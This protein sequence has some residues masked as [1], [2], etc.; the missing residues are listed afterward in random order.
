MRLR[1][2][3]CVL[4]IFITSACVD[5]LHFDLE[6][7]PGLTGMSIYGFISDQPGPYQ[8]SV[9]QTFDIE[10]KESV[11][12]P[13]SVSHVYLSDDVGKTEELMPTQPGIFQT[14][15]TGITGQAGRIY[16]VR[17]EL[18]D[19]R[20]Y[21]SVGDTLLASGIIDSIYYSFNNG[22]VNGT[23]PSYGFDIY[24][25]SS[26]DI[27]HN[28]F[29]WS[30]KATFKSETHP[31]L[32]REEECFFENGICNFVP[33]C[34]GYKNIGTQPAN[35]IFIKV[36]DCECCTCWY[37]IFNSHVLLSD[38]YYSSA[39]N[40]PD[41]KIDRI[42][43]DGWIFMHKLHLEVSMFGLTKQS[44]RFWKAIRDQQNA[45]GNL[46]Q[47]VSGKTPGNFYQVSG[48]ESPALG[49]FYAA[50]V[51]TK[52]IDIKR[53]D[54]PDENLIPSTEGLGIMD[55]RKLFPNATTTRPSFWK[56]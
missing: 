13:A 6:K 35:P 23:T 49:I 16:T 1:K 10:S 14:S 19:G 4:L 12:T 36:S 30:M 54:V 31:E 32:Y 3:E 41:L 2:I 46:F 38:D 51:S 28:R 56:D 33:P 11:K 21:E 39:T 26:N 29:L 53:S 55:C 5:R 7:A 9:Y 40:F 44:F 48:A 17:V 22:S 25:N 34:S 37:D 43:L 18:P 47:P 8:V 52:Q 24:A 45:V 27:E 20:V 50:G 42:P 15:P